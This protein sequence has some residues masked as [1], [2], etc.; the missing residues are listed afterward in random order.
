MPINVGVIG[1]GSL[2]TKRHIAEMAYNPDAR[3]VAFCDNVVSRAQEQA[4]LHHGKAYADYKALLKHPKLQAVVI[5]TPNYLHAPIT[6]AALQAGKHV[7][8]EK[9][10]A[11]SR[12]E[13]QAMIAAADKSG[14]YLMIGQNQRLMPPHVKAKE[15]LDAGKLG[16]PLSFRT[17]F[18]HRG[19]VR[20]CVDKSADTWFFKKKE[21]VMGVCGDLG[22][23]KADLMRFLLG[24]ELVQVSAQIDTLYHTYPNGK[25]IDVDDNAMLIVKSASGVMGSIILSWT[26]FGEAEANYTVIYCEKGVL[27]LAT[28]PQYPVI[29]RYADGG[30]ELHKVGSMATNE[31]QVD[32]FVSQ[33]FLECIRTQTP[34]SIDGWEGYKSLNVIL[35]A[36]DADAQKRTLPVKM[37]K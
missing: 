20:W 10:M 13:A 17:A 7:L 2:G 12:E 35:T 1:C 30:E 21:A 15:I 28:N 4:K 33:T 19:P 5:A 37:P 26:N 9:P 29:V 3:M 24:E 25:L 8:V 22:I 18:K 14:K 32:S 36:F 6:I 31:K 23:H 11:G 16:K 27:M 34:P